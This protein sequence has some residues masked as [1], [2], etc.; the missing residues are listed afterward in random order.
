MTMTVAPRL[1]ASLRPMAMACLRLV[2]FLPEP[3]ERSLPR[4]ISCIAR[5]TFLVAAAP[6]LR[7]PAFLRADALRAPFLVAD[8]RVLFLGPL[9]FLVD[10]F[11]VAMRPCPAKSMPGVGLMA[12]ALALSM[13]AFDPERR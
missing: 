9:L 10:F 3:P 2:T 6:Y 1:R 13:H 4:F 7:P 11:L 5:P 8:L 12:C